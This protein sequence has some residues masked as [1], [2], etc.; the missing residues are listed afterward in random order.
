MIRLGVAKENVQKGQVMRIQ[1]YVF[2]LQVIR[3]LCILHQII[4][5]LRAT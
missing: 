2:I 3:G 1:F 4:I 5:S